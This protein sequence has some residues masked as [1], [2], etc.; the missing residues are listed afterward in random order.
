MRLRRLANSVS[1][2]VS[3]WGRTLGRARLLR[4][5]DRPIEGEND[6][7]GISLTRKRTH[8]GPYRRPM[9]RVLGES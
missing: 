7:S 4:R 5:E 6:Y 2:A 1:D 3:V 8:L 9:P